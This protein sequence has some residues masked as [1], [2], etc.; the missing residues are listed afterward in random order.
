AGS[1]ALFLLG[2]PGEFVRPILLARKERLPVP[3][4]FGVYVLERLFDAASTAI[5]AA[6]GLM[7]FNSRAYSSNQVTVLETAA[8]TTGFVLFGGVFASIGFL[9]Y[10]RLHGTAALSR[11]LEPWLDQP[12]ARAHFARVVLGFAQGIQT[13]RGWGD[14]LLASFY[15][16]AHWILV[17]FVYL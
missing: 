8:R 3:G 13:I 9:V 14:L 2:R 10:L 12:G 4:M 17:L 11:R 1:A 16:A 6:V 7:L 15:S 5:I